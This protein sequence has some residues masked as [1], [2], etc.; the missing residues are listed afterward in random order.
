MAGNLRPQEVTSLPWP[1]AL[2]WSD[3]NMADGVLGAQAFPSSSPSPT[4]SRIIGRTLIML[5][6]SDQTNQH[7]ANYRNC[8]CN[9]ICDVFCYSAM[10]GPL[11]SKLGWCTLIAISLEYR[12]ILYH[13]RGHHEN[14]SH[15]LQLKALS[16]SFLFTAVRWHQAHMIVLWITI[17]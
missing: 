7:L 16:L 10:L 11:K 13:V 17:L 8:T 5:L 9:V 4:W 12:N 6:W 15:Y 1:A 14:E 3:E 2:L